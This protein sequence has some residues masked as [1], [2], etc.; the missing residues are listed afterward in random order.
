MER[1]SLFQL[2]DKTETGKMYLPANPTLT[3]L[4]THF[5]KSPA[6][7]IWM[8]LIWTLKIMLLLQS[9]FQKLLS[10]WKK[11]WE[12]SCWLFHLKTLESM[13]VQQ[14]LI[15]I[16]EESIGI[17]GCPSLTEPTAPLITINLKPITIVSTVKLEDLSNILKTSMRTGETSQ[18]KD[19][20]PFFPI[21]SELVVISCLLGLWHPH[22]L[23]SHLTTLPL[24]Q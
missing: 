11:P 18:E 16:P 9:L 5:T 12:A 20:T 23:E 4:S 2:V 8:E 17:I 13:Q 6:N 19:H 21:S 7:T 1:R 10:N 14:F 22:K 24:E 3:I 15:K